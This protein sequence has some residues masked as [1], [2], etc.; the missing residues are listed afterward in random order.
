MASSADGAAVASAAGMVACTAVVTVPA[1]NE[2]V[3]DRLNLK[4]QIEVLKAQQL[5][6]KK[7]RKQVAK[8][9]RNAV[10]RKKRLQKR[11]RMLTDDDLAAV[12]LLRSQTASASSCAAAPATGSSTTEANGGEEEDM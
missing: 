4:Q 12:L 6:M 11:A 5:G 1:H 2:G 10:K 8:E 3:P 7:Q 9:L